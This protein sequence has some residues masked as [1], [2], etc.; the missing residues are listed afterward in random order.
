MPKRTPRQGKNQTKKT[1]TNHEKYT[2]TYR[3]RGAR[4]GGGFNDSNNGI[5]T[6]HTV[7]CAD[8]NCID[9]NEHPDIGGIE[10][11]DDDRCITPEG[12]VHDVFVQGERGII[13]Q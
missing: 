4:A 13:H 10:H 9:T 5:G 8:D 1:Q 11:P 6:R 2:E 7:V 3:R 12:R